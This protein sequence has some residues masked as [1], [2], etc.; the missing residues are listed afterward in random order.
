MD[1]ILFGADTL[2]GALKKQN[3]LISL[4]QAGGFPLKK[5][6]ANSLLLLADILFAISSLSVLERSRTFSVTSKNH[7][8]LS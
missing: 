3:K 5:W 2:E 6:T 1:D 8:L 7:C 4:C